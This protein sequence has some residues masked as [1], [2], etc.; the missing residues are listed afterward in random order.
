[1]IEINGAKGLSAKTTPLLKADFLL[2]DV[3]HAYSLRQPIC[4]A[5]SGFVTTGLV[6]L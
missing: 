4:M 2:S 5:C 1:M 6:L 3:K